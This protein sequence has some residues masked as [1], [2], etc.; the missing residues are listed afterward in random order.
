[1]LKS[2][3][4]ETYERPERKLIRFNSRPHKIRAWS[5]SVALSNNITLPDILRAS[6]MRS[7]GTSVNHYHR[8][9]LSLNGDEEGKL[10]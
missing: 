8:D 7:T 9:V 4:K 3:K 6:Y 10:T 5:K 2:V 1:M